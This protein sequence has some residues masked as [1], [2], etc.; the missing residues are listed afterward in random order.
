MFTIVSKVSNNSVKFHHFKPLIKFLITAASKRYLR[1]IISYTPIKDLVFHPM[2]SF[3]EIICQM[4]CWN[5]N[6]NAFLCSMGSNIMLWNVLIF[7]IVKMSQWKLWS[8]SMK[9]LNSFMIKRLHDNWK[10][11]IFTFILTVNIVSLK[12]W[13]YFLKKYFVS[14]TCLKV[15]SLC[16]NFNQYTSWVIRVIR[17]YLQ[18]FPYDLLKGWN[19]I[20]FCI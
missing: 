2:T 8:N 19:F 16:F 11:H 10:V 5:S 17:L 9:D 13:V 4:F 3:Y 18:T 1:M 7:L 20:L 12:N 6:S 15:L 14:L